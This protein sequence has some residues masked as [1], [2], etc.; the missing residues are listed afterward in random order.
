MIK[1]HQKYILFT[2]S[3]FRISIQHLSVHNPRRI[4]IC[5]GDQAEND[6]TDSEANIYAISSEGGNVIYH[7]SNAT[8]VL[9]RRSSKESKTYAL[10]T[11]TD[12]GSATRMA[13]AK[14]ETELH[15]D[16]VNATDLNLRMNPFG[17]Q[18]SLDHPVIFDGLEISVTEEPNLNK[19]TR[20]DTETCKK[21]GIYFDDNGEEETNSQASTAVD[22]DVGREMNASEIAESILEDIIDKALGISPAQ[23]Q[24]ILQDSV[25]ICNQ[26]FDSNTDLSEIRS[27]LVSQRSKD[28]ISLGP[29]D[30][31]NA[32]DSKMSEIDS[33]SEADLELGDVRSHSKDD[34]TGVH[35]LHTHILLYTQKY[36]AQRT[37][38]ALSCLKAILITNPRLIICA[39]ST[40]NISSTQ[41]SQF[42]QLQNMLIRHRR[43]VFGKNFFSDV[44]MTAIGSYRTNMYVEILISICLY[45]MRSYY[46][47]LMM[48]KLSEEELNGNKEVQILS[49]EILSL[50]LSELVNVA[51]E[52][53]KGF[54]TYLNDLLL[55]SKVQ[56]VLLHCVLATVYNHRKKTPGHNTQQNITEAII[57]FN[58][59]NMDADALE[60]FQLKLL[61]LLLVCIMLEE[62]IRKL[63]SE[64][65][66]AF[67]L[68]PEWDRIQ[69]NFQPS[70]SSVRYLANKPIVHQS[71]LLS[72]VL[73]SLKQH[74]M[75]HMHRH[76][77][78]MVTAAMPFMGKA[79]SH[80][81][82][83]VVQQL[84]RN[85]ELMASLY[86]L[87]G[88]YTRSVGLLV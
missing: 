82:G 46:P 66:S 64:P 37:L 2:Y 32:I 51:K 41:S 61:R 50:L 30:L 40:T 62:Q 17:S 70:L 22:S 16:R 44:P 78:A 26:K 88:M 38:Y 10:T 4:R 33:Q 12:A 81:V 60:T 31:L 86:E 6:V 53:G 85:I 18:S 56:K 59:E 65:D 69:A 20:L 48:S 24:P 57:S 25:D 55:R 72:A 13:N 47:N 75:S 5:S 8:K 71:M 35:P 49:C 34:V 28:S 52:S 76:W 15:F 11:V 21:E 80:V 36:D 68:P 87:D 67:Q 74:H 1:I 39:L 73:S 45:L 77:I 63:K 43:S 54:A 3:C 7:V 23:S 27:R 58:E 83:T 14:M 19:A 42:V 9:S 79:L 84:C 29:D